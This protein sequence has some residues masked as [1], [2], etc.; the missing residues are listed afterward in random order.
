M[1]NNNGKYSIAQLPVTPRYPE[2]IPNLKQKP[3]G[4]LFNSSIGSDSYIPY[5]LQSQ[6]VSTAFM[7]KHEIHE[8][9]LNSLN[10]NK[11]NPLARYSTPPK[12]VQGY[13][14][15][16]FESVESDRF[17]FRASVSN[18]ILS[19]EKDRD[20][21]KFFSNSDS[22]DDNIEMQIYDNKSNENNDKNNDGD[23]EMKKLR[24]V[25]YGTVPSSEKSLYPEIYPYILKSSANEGWNMNVP[26]INKHSRAPAGTSF[27][28][29]QNQIVNQLKN[30]DDT[31]AYL[32]VHTS[33]ANNDK[34]NVLIDTMNNNSNNNT[35]AKHSGSSS[36]SSS[37]SSSIEQFVYKEPKLQKETFDNPIEKEADYVYLEALKTRAIAVCRFLNNHESYKPWANNWKLLERNLRRNKLLFERLDDTDADIAYVINKGDEVKFRIRD[38]RR[39]IPLNI[40]QYVLYHE[41]AHMSTTELQ[42]TPKFH[43]LLNLISLAGF[44]LGFID[45]SRTTKDFYMTNNQPILCR[46]SLKEE[47]TSGCELMK[48]IHPESKL[49]YDSVKNVVNHKY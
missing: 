9:V 26:D 24:D 31:N 25:R 15:P 11:P 20:K 34:A 4:D 32:R 48:E 47:I 33:N 28:S 7:P 16:S 38:E 30:I 14:D 29:N 45:L 8:R 12:Y 27:I 22:E 42:H 43:E 46:A 10:T 1:S 2:Q 37:P 17:E 49:Y 13:Y 36:N 21:Y 39:Y 5:Q 18:A 40:Y 23:I 35:N 6:E 44:E 19:S 3:V 41:M